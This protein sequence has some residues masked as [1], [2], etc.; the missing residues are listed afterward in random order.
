MDILFPIYF[1]I[2]LYVFSLRDSFIFALLISH[3]IKSREG[4]LVYITVHV[5]CEYQSMPRYYPRTKRP[6]PLTVKPKL[7]TQRMISSQRLIFN[8]TQIIRIRFSNHQSQKTYS[9]LCGR[10]LHQH[11]RYWLSVQFKETIYPNLRQ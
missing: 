4:V 2:F 1:F 8:S 10:H 5:A 9:F 3:L 6:L 7:I 11:Q